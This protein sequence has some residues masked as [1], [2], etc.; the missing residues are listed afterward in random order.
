MDSLNIETVD[1]FSPHIARL[2]SPRT[3]QAI[4]QLGLEGKDLVYIPK[5]E[6]LR[7]GLGK[8]LAEQRFSHHEARRA[9]YIAEVKAVRLEIARNTGESPKRKEAETRGKAASPV[10]EMEERER[11]LLSKLQKHKEKQLDLALLSEARQLELLHDLEEA[12]QREASREKRRLEGLQRKQRTIRLQKLTFETAIS[13]RSSSKEPLVV[14][15]KEDSFDLKLKELQVKLEKRSL[16]RQKAKEEVLNS[17][18]GERVDDGLAKRMKVLETEESWIAMQSE[19]SLEVEEKLRRHEENLREL[20]EKRSKQHSERLAQ[21]A[22]K[23]ERLKSLERDKARQLESTRQQLALREHSAEQRYL[24]HFRLKEEH[25]TSL[26]QKEALKQE[27]NLYRRMAKREEEQGKAEVLIAGMRE[28]ELKFTKKRENMAKEWAIRREIQAEQRSDRYKQAQRLKKV[29]EYQRGRILAQLQA[30]ERQIAALQAAKGREQRLKQQLRK[31]M[32]WEKNLFGQQFDRLLASHSRE[33][34]LRSFQRPLSLSPTRNQVASLTPIA[35]PEPSSLNHSLSEV[36]GQLEE[37]RT[38]HDKE[39][40][41]QLRLENERE[42]ERS[43]ELARTKSEAET[44]ELES[45][46]RQERALANMRIVAL[47]E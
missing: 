7:Q 5:S 19:H 8:D 2:T 42:R 38:K 13:K 6:F 30:E 16:E 27:R 26:A 31:E 34:L 4:Q 22:L 45:R 20:K 39:L 14:G 28:N 37:I 32:E 29:E 25:F 1:P 18:G 41:E 46:F 10:R 23:A 24:S 12:K 36:S 43:E 9:K 44:Q 40:M 3:L 15:F 33:K 21:A 17:S 35:A 11:K 47:S